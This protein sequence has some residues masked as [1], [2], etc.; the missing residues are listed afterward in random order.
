MT[1]GGDRAGGTHGRAATVIVGGP[2]SEHAVSLVTGAE[3]LTRLRDGGRSARPV[4]ITHGGRWHLGDARDAVG[5]LPGRVARSAA[6]VL[7][8]LHDDGDV[9][10]LG[11]HGRFG[12]DG[13]VQR[14]LEEADV[15]YTGS[16]PI[17]SAICMDKD[18]SKRAALEV[19]AHCATHVVVDTL[20]APLKR[21]ES[22]VGLP[23]VVK[24][25]C[26]GSSVATSIVRH[27]EDLP[28]AL[29]A[30]CSEDPDGRALVEA[31]VPGHELTCAVLRRD[32][33]AWC[34]PL[35]AIEP[36][37]GSFYDYRAKYESD[38]TRLVCPA[39]V[40]GD[41]V[42]DIERVSLGLHAA[43]QLRGVVRLDFMLAPGASRAAFL[44]VNTLPGMTSHSL[45]P[46]AAR[47]A[48]L[49]GPELMELLLADVGS[50][51]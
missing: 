19:G 11:L 7:E 51:G 5:D 21:L 44:E 42:D 36:R 20:P 22:Q 12:E 39:P 43:L 17:A 32:G 18:L 24:P 49:G 34:L 45:V 25:V 13:S 37:G 14:L 33:E 31:F 47:A 27:R 15:P 30:A 3:M 28:A 8:Q 4:L 23:C 6:D 26:G 35:V 2:S 46:L 16:G 9:A 41:I 50:G 38:E 1:P 40:T 29:R 48:G 10:V